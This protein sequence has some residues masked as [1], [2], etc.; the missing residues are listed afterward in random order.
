[1]IL[2]IQKRGDEVKKIFQQG[3]TR[4]EVVHASQLDTYSYFMVYEVFS[5][6]NSNRMSISVVIIDKEEYSELHASSSGGGK[7]WLFRFDWGSGKG[8]EENIKRIFTNAGVQ[9]REING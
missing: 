8:F 7:G 3:Q 6:M 4:G 2:R 5:M 9:F 1:M